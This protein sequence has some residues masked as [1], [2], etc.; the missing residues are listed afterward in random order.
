MWLFRRRA[1]HEEFTQTAQSSVHTHDRT[2]PFIW[3]THTPI[4]GDEFKSYLPP[5]IE[6]PQFP[7]F[8]VKAAGSHVAVCVE[9]TAERRS[10]SLPTVTETRALAASRWKTPQLQWLTSGCKV[11]LGFTS[12]PACVRSSGWLTVCAPREWDAS[13]SYTLPRGGGPAS[14]LLP[15]TTPAAGS[16]NSEVYTVNTRLIV[17]MLH[18]LFWSTG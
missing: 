15:F 9:C 3:I 8:L 14:S 11:W 2:G 1:H 18:F 13:V 7:L 12:H 16:H 4:S 6:L 10:V 5:T 17:L